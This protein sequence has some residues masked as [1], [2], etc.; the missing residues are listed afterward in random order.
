MTKSYK[1]KLVK[2]R[3]ALLQGWYSLDELIEKFVE[4]RRYQGGV[5]KRR[6]AL[7]CR[8]KKKRVVNGQTEFFMGG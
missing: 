1:N 6:M 3:L 2:Q 8:G 7:L 5:S 4:D